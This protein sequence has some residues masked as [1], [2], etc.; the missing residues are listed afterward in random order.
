[1]SLDIAVMGVVDM[2]N[3]A[4]TKWAGYDIQHASS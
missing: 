1:M 4:C 3:V 2:D